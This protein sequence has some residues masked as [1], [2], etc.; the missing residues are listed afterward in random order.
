VVQR[1]LLGGEGGWDYVI[2]DTT[3][4]R[5]FIG[6]QNRVMVVDETTGKLLGEVPGLSAAHGIA[7]DHATN[8]GFATSGRDSSVVMFDLQT[9]KV[10]GRATAAEDADAILYDPTSKLV[11]TFNGDAGSSS[12][13]DPTTGQRVANIVLGGKPEY[14]VSAGDGKLYANIEDKSELVEIDTRAR[15]VTRRWS[16]APCEEPSGLAIDRANHLLFS[17]CRNRRMA[18]S[19]A[20]NGKL[21]TTVPIGPG[22][23]ANAFDAGTG[24]AFA[25]NGGDGTLTIVHEDAPDRFHV[26]ANV[27]TMTGAR[28]MALDP[29][30]HRVYLVGAE[31]GP[32]PAQATPENPRRRPPMI[33]GSFTLLVLER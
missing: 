9:L 1:Y 4:N 32:A 25:S 13:I 28:T 19:N 31:F 20:T 2:V 27:A 6:R 21:V 33:P 12:A 18:I 17:G 10:L 5:I 11:Y 15:R 22:V 23:D 26:V 7:V 30:T 14:G 3:S 24:D 8:H 16:L 29:R